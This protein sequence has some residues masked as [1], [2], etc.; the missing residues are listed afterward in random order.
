M[1][2]TINDVRFSYCN[3]FQ[4]QVRPGGKPEDAKYSV[5]IL[6]PKSNAQAKAIIDAA[7]QDAVTAGVSKV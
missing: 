1:P 4:P 2:T 6:V 5:T 7:I 3:L